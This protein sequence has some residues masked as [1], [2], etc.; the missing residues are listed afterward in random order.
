MDQNKSVVS[1]TPRGKTVSTTPIRVKR[2]TKR[3]L[4]HEISEINKK[5]LGRRVKMD[6]LVRLLLEELKPSH[7]EKL[8]EKSLSN[9][10]R[11][12]KQYRDYIA[13]HGKIT[14]DE[15]LGKLLEVSKVPS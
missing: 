9:K 13:G 5:K 1:A 11:L 12:E 7:F 4:N 10:D 3:R 2:D 15:Y 8:Q 6:D 14:M